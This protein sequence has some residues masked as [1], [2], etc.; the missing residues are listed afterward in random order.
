MNSKP[1]LGLVGLLRLLIIGLE[2]I[3]ALL[4]IRMLGLAYKLAIKVGPGTALLI[5]LAAGGYHALVRGRGWRPK[6]ETVALVAGGGLVAI[7]VGGFGQTGLFWSGMAAL[8]FYWRGLVAGFEMPS[9]D[10]FKELFFKGLAA[11]ILAALARPILSVNPS[12][13]I[14]LSPMEQGIYSYFALFLLVGTLGLSLSRAKAAAQRLGNRPVGYGQWASSALSLTTLLSALAL[15]A[16]AAVI[17]S[18]R[19][20]LAMLGSLVERILYYLLLPIGWLVQTLVEFLGRT[21]YATWAER[22][23]KPT[24]LKESKPEIEEVVPKDSPQWVYLVLKVLL[25]LIILVTLWVL[26]SRLV[27]R[28]NQNRS[29]DDVCEERSS[30]WSWRDFKD[31]LWRRRL[32]GLRGSGVPRDL[33]EKG[34]ARARVRQIY[35]ALLALG[36]K[37]GRPR[38]SGETPREYEQPLA[39]ALARAVNAKAG[40]GAGGTGAGGTGL[41]GSNAEFD[42]LAAWTAELTDRYMEARYAPPEATVNA[43]QAE[44]A[45][46]KVKQKLK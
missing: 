14:R 29:T 7:G 33:A 46:A 19:S 6:A 5:M 17:P 32:R 1:D 38:H 3:P 11:S 37:I 20:G 10:V 41:G 24:Q 28:F 36:N 35:R 13:A 27:R 9:S 34:P 21:G 44:E 18:A 16:A 22:I 45:W 40:S 23:L 31:S 12:A 4:W 25:G 30:M 39:E 15:L 2:L 26:F 43:E 8:Y 42:E